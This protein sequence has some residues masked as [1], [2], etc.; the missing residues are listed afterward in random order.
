MISSVGQQMP[1]RAKP[2]EMPHSVK[3]Y[4]GLH[5]ITNA[6]NRGFTCTKGLPFDKKESLI[7]N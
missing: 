1:M 3:F 2:G 4:L 7:Q 6:W 5:Y